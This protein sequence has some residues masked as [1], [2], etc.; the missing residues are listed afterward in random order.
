MFYKGIH[1]TI[2]TSEAAD[3]LFSNITDCNTPDVSF[4]A[5]LRA[6]LRKRLPPNEYVRLTCTNLNLTEDTISDMTV[7]QCMDLFASQVI[8]TPHL[9]SHTISIVYIN[10]SIEA[11]KKMLE[12]V[13]V[14]AGTGKRYLSNYNRREDLRVFYARK[15]GALFYMFLSRKNYSEN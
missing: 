10:N 15:F 4:L 7:S 14:N 13:R 12:I 1:E 5:T 11:G 6:L 8:Q 3:R 2:L 9:S